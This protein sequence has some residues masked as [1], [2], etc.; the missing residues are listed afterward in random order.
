MRGRG[1]NYKYVQLE[2]DNIAGFI[3]P[4]ELYHS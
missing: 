3:V 2:I 4:G 1:D